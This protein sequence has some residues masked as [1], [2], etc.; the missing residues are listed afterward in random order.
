MY[1]YKQFKDDQAARLTSVSAVFSEQ[2]KLL[3]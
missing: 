2:E 3:E 1:K